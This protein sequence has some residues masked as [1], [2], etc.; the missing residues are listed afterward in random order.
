MVCGRQVAAVAAACATGVGA[1]SHPGTARD[2]AGGRRLRPRRLTTLTAAAAGLVHVAANAVVGQ[3]HA[4]G[5]G[6]L[7]VGTEP[8]AAAPHTGGGAPAWTQ[9]ALHSVGAAAAAAA[10]GG[11]HGQA[12]AASRAK[13]VR[14][15]GDPS[16]SAPH[17]GAPPPPIS[18]GGYRRP[19]AAVLAAPT[20]LADILTV[21]FPGGHIEVA[22]AAAALVAAAA[23]VVIAAEVVAAVV[24]VIVAALVARRRRRAES[25]SVASSAIVSWG[26]RPVGA[27]GWMPGGGHTVGGS[28]TCG[29]TADSVV[30]GMEDGCND[31]CK[32]AAK[33]HAVPACGDAVEGVAGWDG[34]GAVVCFSVP[35]RGGTDAEVPPAGGDDNHG[36]PTAAVES[37]DEV[38]EEGLEEAAEDDGATYIDRDDYGREGW[39]VAIQMASVMPVVEL[40][41]REAQS[42]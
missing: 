16:P 9:P 7:S 34:E 8:A 19:S 21:V 20:A 18:T 26:G 2:G 10:T 31:S 33:T 37:E 11:N 40:P 5:G 41:S 6:W 35:T 22:A 23:A 15:G 13:V 17:Y 32:A 28:G 3:A 30:G 42:V 39:S 38:G 14:A 24:D 27:T 1:P 25:L 12:L 36:H 4:M 29:W